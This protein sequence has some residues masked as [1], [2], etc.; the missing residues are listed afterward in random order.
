MRQKSVVGSLYGSA[1]PHKTFA[2]VVAL[3][4]K[5][6]LDIEGLRAVEEGENGRGVLA[7]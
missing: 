7:F 4:L 1:T 2:T 5:G 3:Y 6:M